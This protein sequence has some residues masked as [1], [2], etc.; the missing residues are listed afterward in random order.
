MKKKAVGGAKY[1]NRAQ[2]SRMSSFHID[3][4]SLT[5]SSFDISLSCAVLRAGGARKRGPAWRLA[6]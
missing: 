4:L 6:R 3:I 1:K 2:R 5:Y